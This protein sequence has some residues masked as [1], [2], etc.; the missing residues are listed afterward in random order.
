MR[1]ENVGQILR[2][3]DGLR[4]ICDELKVIC[5]EYVP[6]TPV[7]PDMDCLEDATFADMW[8]YS[9]EDEQSECKYFPLGKGECR[10]FLYEVIFSLTTSSSHHHV[11]VKETVGVNLVEECTQ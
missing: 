10:S 3:R 6:P 2:E 5:N 8:S 9:E 1:E 7:Q 11:S 4:C